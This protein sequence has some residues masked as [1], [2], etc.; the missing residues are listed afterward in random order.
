MGH[1][2]VLGLRG[3]WLSAGKARA[4]WYA[5]LWGERRSSG[6][7]GSAGTPRPTRRGGNPA[8]RFALAWPM[9]CVG[10][11]RASRP[12]RA[13][14]SSRPAVSPIQAPQQPLGPTR[15]P[16]A[17]HP[18]SSPESGTA[19]NRPRQRPKPVPPEPRRSRWSR[20]AGPVATGIPAPQ[21]PPVAETSR[22]RRSSPT[23]PRLNSCTPAISPHGSP[24]SFPAPSARCSFVPSQ[25]WPAR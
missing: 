25:T 8:G 9:R 11:G 20:A 4:I 14:A 3:L 12:W 24:C 15:P 2:W 13:G 16:P 1:R 19:A 7:R 10:N 6:S 21:A 18:P 17:G 5:R 22:A 23:P